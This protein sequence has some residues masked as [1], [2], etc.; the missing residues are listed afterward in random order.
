M[1]SWEGM[2]FFSGTK[3]R[4]HSSFSLPKSARPNQ[5][6][7]PLV[8]AQTVN[9]KMSINECNFLRSMRGSLRS[10]KWFTNM[11]FISLEKLAI[12]A[13]PLNFQEF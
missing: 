2:P 4:S 3:R 5:P 8:T 11:V 13:Q 9:T 10:A 7:A 6:S 1:Q 12:S